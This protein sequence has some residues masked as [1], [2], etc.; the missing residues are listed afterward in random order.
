MSQEFE[1]PVKQEESNIQDTS[2]ISKC[3][4]PEI[5]DISNSVGAKGKHKDL[6]IESNFEPETQ[7]MIDEL[8]KHVDELDQINKLDFP[9]EVLIKLDTPVSEGEQNEA[10][11]LSDATSDYTSGDE[12]VL[13]EEPESIPTIE[14]VKS[15]EKRESIDDF[16]KAWRDFDW[17]CAQLSPKRTDSNRVYSNSC[18]INNLSHFKSFSPRKILSYN[19]RR[20]FNLQDSVISNKDSKIKSENVEEQI[21]KQS[22]FVAAE[23]SNQLKEITT[24]N[25]VTTTLSTNEQTVQEYKGQISVERR[26]EGS[27][28]S[29]LSSDILP[30][31][32]L[33]RIKSVEFNSSQKINPK[34][35][36][37]FRLVIHSVTHHTK[38]S[39]SIEEKLRKMFLFPFDYHSYVFDALKFDVYDH[40]SFLNTKKRLGR[41]IVRLRN[42]KEAILNKKEFEG[43]FP[44]ETVEFP[45]SHEV[46][47][48]LLNIKFHYPDDPPLTPPTP[49]QPSIVRSKSDSV[50]TKQRSISDVSIKISD[51]DE[52]ELDN[53]ILP[54]NKPLGILDMVL[55]QE[56]RDAIKEITVLY[57]AFFDHGWRLTKLEFLKA[58][59]LLEK[60]YTQKPN[61]V[62]GNLFHNSEKIKVAQY[63]LKYSM[64]SYG[65]FLFN[66]FGYG[67]NMAPLNAFR[68]NSDRKAVQ[69][70]FG[71]DKGDIICWEY[72]Q[73]TVS[74]PNYMIVRDPETNSIVISIRGTMN[75][76]DAITDVL[77]HYEPW[78]GGVVH[79]GILRSAQYLVNHSLADIRS[80]VAKFKSNAIQVVGHSLGASI[81]SIVTILLR[82]QCKDLLARGVDIHAWNFATAPCCSLDLSCDPESVKCIDNFIN[83]NDIIPRLSYGNLMDFKE[84]VKFA[85]SE[86]KNE[87]YKKLNSRDKLTKI[88]AAIDD[89]R[90][91]L[92]LNSS[93]QKLYI[94][95]NIY[96]LYKGFHRF[97]TK[98]IV[99]EVS[100][101]DLFTDVSLRRNWLFHHFPDRY[102]KKF[103]GVL[104]YLAKKMNDQELDREKRFRRK[105]KKIEDIESVG[106][107]GG[108]A[109]RWISR[110]GHI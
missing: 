94:P 2:Q 100:R 87:I 93:E 84:L 46:G 23:K 65:S 96:Y 11:Y 60:Y 26:S 52:S 92:K 47:T 22:K 20:T 8:E 44:L 50:V 109:E 101:P 83:E 56:T 54:E 37:S 28:D 106:E 53:I 103:K 4:N 3:T 42:L 51:A 81:S 19:S 38:P 30:D 110:S 61:P 95:G 14:N 17:S 108:R 62:T 1:G 33:V 98:D 86:L 102:D 6:M 91:S 34:A 74:V 35:K 90:T 59:M 41:S 107:E 72:G 12:N 66:F 31:M 67:H 40:G 45:N 73:R 78:N 21:Q 57:H 79:R 58:Y 89:Y 10:N 68:M 36:T 85:A 25:V 24:L 80:A 99:C 97:Y 7:S 18:T 15:H 29:L 70:F 5:P 9:H 63:Y 76:T 27:S 82:E 43:T 39:I 88:I 48:I 16:E 105:W 64:A 55:S 69:D 75:I 77:T 49:S 71:L 32:M 13:T 104:K